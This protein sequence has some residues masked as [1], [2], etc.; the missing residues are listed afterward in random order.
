MNSRTSALFALLPARVTLPLVALV[1]VMVSSSLTAD[2]PDLDTIRRWLRR[3]QEL[4]VLGGVGLAVALS[5]VFIGAWV[6]SHL[7][8]AKADEQERIEWMSK[9]ALFVS[10]VPVALT[11]VAAAGMFIPMLRPLML[12]MFVYAAAGAGIS[13]LVS[14]AAL[15]VGGGKEELARTRRALLLAG[16]PFYCLAVW[17]ARFLVLGF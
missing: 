13:W 8:T 9:L 2:L 7:R 14:I 11:V 3:L 1:S 10:F 16:T 15:I 17:I 5:M 4:I 12:K 6:L